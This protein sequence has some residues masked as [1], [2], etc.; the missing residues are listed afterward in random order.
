MSTSGTGGLRGPEPGE[1]RISIRLPPEVLLGAVLL[2]LA[3][4]A[5]LAVHSMA[6]P[7]M[8]LGLLTRSQADASARAMGSMSI[9]AGLFLAMWLVMMT[10]MMLPAVTPVLVRV[11]R[12]MRARDTGH[13][14]AYAMAGGYLLVWGATGIAAYGVYL[15]FQEAV[16]AG[17]AV[18]VRAGAGV[19]LLVGVYQLTPLK[20]ACLRQCRSPLA[21]VMRHGQAIASGPSGAARAGIRHGLYCAGCC[22][23]LMVV[24]LAVGAMSLVWMGVITALILVEKVHRHGEGLSLVLGSLLIAAAVALVVAPDLLLVLA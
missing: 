4:A 15:A 20:R 7:D 5:W 24:L 19:L 18:A 22:W 8:R 16:P 10:A 13:G 3:A 1:T 2:A 21:V 9:G 11:Q 23:A 17:G 12:L 6:M 14:A